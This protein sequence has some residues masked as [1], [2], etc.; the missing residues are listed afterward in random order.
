MART[1]DRDSVWTGLAW[2]SPW[3]LGFGLFMATPIVMSLYYSFTDYPLLEKPVFVGADNYVALL[4]DEVFF[5]TLR[6]TAIFC[7]LYIPSASVLALVIAAMLNA[8]VKALGL[9]RTAVFIP[10]LVP[11]VASAMIW[12]WLF[13]A[14]QGLLNVALRAVGISGPNWLGDPAWA[15]PALVL[16]SLWNIGQP[17]VIYLA[18][19][20]GVPTSL[21]EAASIDGMGPVRK[22]LY[23]TAPM[24]SPVILFNVIIMTINTLQVFAVPYIMT[25]GGPG[26][27]TYFFTHY[28][29]DNAFVFLK[30]GYASALAWVQFLIILALTGVMFIA[31]RKL[32][33]YRTG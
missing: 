23:V 17:V 32:V 4:S 24:I 30:M 21:Y 2:I 7:L 18:A 5:I 1:G 12:L 22:L 16:M 10:S 26:R 25:E 20:Q 27:A 19:L 11:I 29:Y 28:L 6:N 13:N 14:D 33:H 9:W 31:S 15:L 3:I 8:R